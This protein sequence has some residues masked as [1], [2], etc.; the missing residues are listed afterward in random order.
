MT[1]V[2]SWC[3][4]ILKCVN[5]LS[6]EGHVHWGGRVAVEVG[7]GGRWNQEQTN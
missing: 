5:L 6:S 7:G 4:G 2:L 1:C 3:R